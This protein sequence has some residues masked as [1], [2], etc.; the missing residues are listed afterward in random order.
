MIWNAQFLAGLL[1]LP[2]ENNREA[3][4]VEKHTSTSSYH[5]ISLP[6]SLDVM[7]VGPLEKETL[8][9]DVRAGQDLVLDGVATLGF[10]VLSQESDA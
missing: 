5:L 6:K 8:Q 9:M 7:T 2:N 4:M 10:E 3:E 1:S